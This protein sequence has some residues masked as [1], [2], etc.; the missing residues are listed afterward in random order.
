M[1][2]RPLQLLLAVFIT[3]L[4]SHANAAA[5][6]SLD[7]TSI[8]INETV[9]LTIT[10]DENTL[11]SGPDLAGVE[12]NF[13]IL[14][15]NKSSQSS[16][17]NG[18]KT[19][20][21]SWVYQLAPK[22]AGV[23]TIPAIDVDGS[24]TQPLGIQVK[25]ADNNPVGKAGS[26]PVF[27]EVSTDKKSVSV[28]EQLILTVRINSSVNL[29]DLQLQNIELE[30]AFIQQINE[31]NYQRAIN[32]IPHI[33]Y[34][35]VY[36]I[37]PQT[38]GKLV[39]PAVTAS[40]VA[41]D[42]NASRGFGSIFNSGKPLRIRSNPLEVTVTEVPPGI[43][44]SNWLPAQE[45]QLHESWSN[46]PTSIHLGDSITRTIT[47]TAIGLSGEQLPPVVINGGPHLK[48]YPDQPVFEDKKGQQGITG[49]RKDAI[50]LVA[51]SPGQV[52]LPEITVEWWDVTEKTLKRAHL[53][54]ITL[55]VVGDAG[56]PAPAQ[57][58]SSP[59]ISSQPMTS[60]PATALP[61]ATAAASPMPGNQPQQLLPWQIAT[62][63]ASALAMLFLG[64]WLHARY[65]YHGKA[66]RAGAGNHPLAAT[67]IPS[68]DL[69]LQQLQQACNDHDSKAIR[70]AILHWARITWP[71]TPLHS[72]IDVARKFQD[73]AFS[74]RIKILDA[75]LYSGTTTLEN[76]QG[77]YDKVSARH[78]EITRKNTGKLAP[79]YPVQ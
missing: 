41:L 20:R 76:W 50:A 32:G 71:D 22:Q 42:Q 33:T 1:V 68:A 21:T 65:R 45:L 28:Q 70:A 18:Q 38:S 6:A 30:N 39:I 59:P 47:T 15:S 4:C 49:V 10:L 16:W 24:L 75:E 67:A 73:N 46:D 66:P 53:P 8:S 51:T 60:P 31:S 61:P 72:T 58:M 62:A 27:I 11:F 57:S 25:P 43:S 74:E 56:T 40:A 5:T 3:L 7:R 19:A 2:T 17:I 37:F 36:A 63:L 79:L 64:L 78:K 69:A 12:Q 26:E 9:E 14:G 55:T 34:E 48:I 13:E 54:E 29:N 77:L 52:T 44:A 23:F 35:V